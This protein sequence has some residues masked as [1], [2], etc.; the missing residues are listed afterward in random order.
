MAALVE[1]QVTDI[2]HWNDT[3]F[4]FKTTRSDSF[5]FE[6]GHFVMLGLKIDGKPLLRAYSIAS[7]NYDEYLEFFSIKVQDGPLTSRLQH[8]QVGDSVLVSKKPVGT[9]VIDDLNPGKRL[10][11]LAT[12]TGLAPFLSITKDPNAYERFEEILLVHC[13]RE[14]SEL[15]YFDYFNDTLPNDEVLGELITPKLRYLPTV[16]REAF[17]TQGRITTLMED[18]TLNLDPEKDRVML[19]GSQNMLRDVSAALDTRGFAASPGQGQAGDYVLERAFVE[20]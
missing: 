10:V 18:G 3:L 8:L 9:L 4:S 16:T 20:Q 6:N 19:C 12:G 13:V 15:A 14:K 17:T 7:A 5:R 2:R 11:L 1:E